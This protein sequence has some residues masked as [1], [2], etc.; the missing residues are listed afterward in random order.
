MPRIS[1]WVLTLGIGLVIGHCIVCAS[2]PPGPLVIAHRGASGL[3]PEHTL[4]AYDLAIDLGAGTIE[5]D[6]QL[7]RDGILII[8]HDE[9]LDRTARGPAENC[10]GP[11][12]QKT[13]AAL[14]T[15]DFGVWFD[16]RVPG[17]GARFAGQRIVTLEALF[18]R[19]GTRVRYYIETKHPEQAPGVEQALLSL[20]ATHALLPR[21]GEESPVIVQS[22][23]AESLRRIRA[24]QPD[25][26]LVQ[27]LDEDLETPLDEQF[28]VIAEYA[29]GVGPHRSDVDAAFMAEARRHGLIV[30]PYTVNEQAEMIRL[31]DLGADGLFTDRTDRLVELLRER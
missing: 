12:H 29:V 8:L 20:L 30:H 9:T 5:Q 1:Y 23:S 22:F 7:T 17:A 6:L 21:Q 19:Y 10:T 27:L 3:A 31:L 11:V 13:L 25:L 24:L 26:P 15:C 18:Q 2:A 28:S 16:D 4:A 14:Q